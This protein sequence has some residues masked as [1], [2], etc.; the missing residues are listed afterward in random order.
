MHKSEAVCRV[1]ASAQKTLE[2]PGKTPF[3]E[4]SADHGV[5]CSADF[6]KSLFFRAFNSV[7]CVLARAR[8]PARNCCESKIWT[9]KQR[10]NG[11]RGTERLR[12]ARGSC[13]PI[14]SDR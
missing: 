1:C 4:K 12:V 8:Q 3:F 5:R 10:E 9:R 6:S 11:V 14:G 13:A 2:K 7:F